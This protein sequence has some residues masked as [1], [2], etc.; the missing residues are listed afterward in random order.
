M[1]P[2]QRIP[3]LK[4]LAAALSA[5]E[6]P[7]SETDLVLRQHGFKSGKVWF[8]D[9]D[10]D[11]Y[12][13]PRFDI[14]LNHLETSEDDEKL[15][16]LERYLDPAAD[17]AGSPASIDPGPW[18][19]TTSFRLFVSH[20]N[21]NAKFATGIKTF[22]WKYRIECFV[23][24]NDITPSEKWREVIRAALLTTHAMTAI[25]TPDFRE[26]EWCDQE[27]GFALA[28]SMLVVPVMCGDVPP[29]GFLSEFQAIKLKD[30]TSAWAAATRLFTILA[31]HK[32]T[33]DRMAGPV[34]RRYAK[35]QNFPEASTAYSLLAGIP[36]DAWTPELVKEC[37]RAATDNPTVKKAKT[38][39]KGTS[40]PLAAAT[41]LA[42]IEQRL[43]MAGD[44]D[45]PF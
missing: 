21:G 34:V 6:M 27:I 11:A 24:H 31:K 20:T 44:A 40:I 22:L 12:L 26:S 33:R 17:Q 15:L 1:K 25:V 37:Q 29:H 2:A 30:T 16:E 42:P 36:K 10:G 13:P 39:A 19:A 23:A 38:S 14:A 7:Q 41:L 4:K 28:R 45:I 32:E 9:D 18:K 3:L 35:S 8:A 43:G 5:E